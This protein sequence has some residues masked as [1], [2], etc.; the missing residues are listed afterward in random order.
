MRR[1]TL[2][3]EEKRLTLRLSQTLWRQLRLEAARRDVNT[4]L[5]INQILEERL[6]DLRRRELEPTLRR[7]QALRQREANWNGYGA[8]PPELQ[9]VAIAETWL[10]ALYQEARFALLPVEEAN[11]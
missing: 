5:L 9:A 7:I 2:P 1:T 6:G 11:A 4:T 3:A 10:A 8:L